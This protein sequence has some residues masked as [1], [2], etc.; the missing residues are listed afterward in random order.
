LHT[1]ET[2]LI[3]ID[4]FWYSICKF[5][6][7]G[8]YEKNEKFYLKR[9]AENYIN[10]F[11]QV[12]EKHKELFFNK[13]FNIISQGVFYSFFYAFPISRPRFDRKLAKNI[14][15]TFSYQFTGIEF[16]N[17]NKLLKDWRLDLGTGNVLK[18]DEDK[19][20]NLPEITSKRSWKKSTTQHIGKKK[21]KKRG[22]NVKPL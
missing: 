22:N 4:A 20:T 14:L 9:I 2:S 18:I 11:F 12:N 1:K 8:R 3:I 5:F 15:L 17:L 19:D 10:F 6:F 7:P 16:S 13:Y 21:G